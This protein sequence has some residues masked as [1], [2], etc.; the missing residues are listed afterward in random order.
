MPPETTNGIVTRYS[1]QYDGSVIDNFGSKTLNML[2]G[3]VES[4]S[5][6]TTYLLQLKA[7]TRVGPGPPSSLTVKTCK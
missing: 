4:L 5:P 2:I 1:I 6:D 3:T 7:H